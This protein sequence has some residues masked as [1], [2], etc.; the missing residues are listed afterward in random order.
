ME[1]SESEEWLCGGTDTV[2][3]NGCANLIMLSKF[4]ILLRYTSPQDNGWK[5]KEKVL[6]VEIPSA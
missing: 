3:F 6:L 2:N 4:E 1:E 5:L